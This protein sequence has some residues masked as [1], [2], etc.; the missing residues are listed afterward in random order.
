MISLTEVAE[1]A[2]KGPKLNEKEWGMGMFRKM[3][4]L[5]DKHELKIGDVG[6]FYEVDDGYADQ[7]FDAAV[8]YLS[9]MG[10]YCISTN[11]AIRFTEEE[12]KAK[13]VEAYRH[14]FGIGCSAP[15]V[16]SRWSSGEMVIKTGSTTIARGITGHG[17][18]MPVRITDSCG[19]RGT[20]RSGILY[21]PF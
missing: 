6:K 11:R 15:G 2:Q 13:R 14:F 18:R 4:E 8:E 3:Q 16:G 5:A 12:V 21:L 9:M 20:K 7:L 19:D 17:I 1:R 10:V